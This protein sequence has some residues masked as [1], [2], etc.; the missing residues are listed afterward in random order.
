MKMTNCET[1]Q[2]ESLPRASVRYRARGCLSLFRRGEQAVIFN[3]C[4]RMSRWLGATFAKERLQKILK[5]CEYISTTP[6]IPGDIQFL[7]F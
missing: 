5:S 7:A 1:N 3:H 4:F 6:V 2:A